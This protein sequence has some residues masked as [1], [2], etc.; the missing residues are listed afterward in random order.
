MRRSLRGVEN[1]MTRNMFQFN[2]P[3]TFQ[4]VNNSHNNAPQKNN[5]PNIKRNL[6]A[7]ATAPDAHQNV[8]EFPD[9]YKPYTLN[10]T[11]DGY[12]Y[13]ILGG[14]GVLGLCY[15]NDIKEMK[16]R[17][18]RKIFARSDLTERKLRKEKYGAER[19]AANDPEFTKFLVK[20]ERSHGHH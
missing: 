2:Y 13:A 15:F 10:Y 14:F 5:Y 4:N 12:L 17:K 8:R 7:G 6:A 11:S 9:W 18:Q 3:H 19:I 20:K 1:T 16:G